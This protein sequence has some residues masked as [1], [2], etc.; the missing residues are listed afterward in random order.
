MAGSIGELF[1]LVKG[2]DTPPNFSEL[3]HRQNCIE[4]GFYREA[5]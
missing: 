5:C 1:L 3:G 2:Y 4:I